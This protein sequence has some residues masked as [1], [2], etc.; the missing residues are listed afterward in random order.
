MCSRVKRIA[1]PV[2]GRPLCHPALG[3]LSGPVQGVESSTLHLPD[4][5]EEPIVRSGRMTQ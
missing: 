3:V 1:F 4:R 5:A 2:S